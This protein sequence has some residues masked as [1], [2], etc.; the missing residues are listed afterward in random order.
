VSD[1]LTRLA[2][3]SLGEAPAVRPRLPGLFA[4]LNEEPTPAS[5][6]VVADVHEPPPALAPAPFFRAREAREET[7]GAKTADPVGSRAPAAAERPGDSMPARKSERQAAQPSGDDGEAAA[8]ER[9][10][11]NGLVPARQS[12]EPGPS[13]VLLVEKVAPQE[14]LPAS[15]LPV[16]QPRQ[17]ASA[18]ESTVDPAS[19]VYLDREPA[20]APAVHITIGRIE[21][22]ASIAPPPARTRPDHMPALSLRDYL[23]RGGDKP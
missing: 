12:A 8:L 13:R 5:A 16:A 19:L 21:V 1:F 10:A 2:L 9:R 11:P 15:P 14:Q 3:R 17:R 20:Q 6:A 18:Q 23:K 4:P 7:A 22:R